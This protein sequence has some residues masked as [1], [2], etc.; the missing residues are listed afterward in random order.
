MLKKGN[1]VKSKLSSEKQNAEGDI[2][3]VDEDEEVVEGNEE[4]KVEK[5]LEDA[6]VA[7]LTNNTVKSAEQP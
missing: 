2:A 3:E 5:N 1:Q 6:H 7:Q 4:Q